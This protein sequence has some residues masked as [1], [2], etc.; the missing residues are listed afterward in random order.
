M[1]GLKNN[2]SWVHVNSVSLNITKDEYIFEVLFRD[3]I[4]LQEGK[5]KESKR[6]A[7]KSR[8]GEVGGVGRGKVY[9]R[10]LKTEQ[11][12]LKQKN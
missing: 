3:A 4:L 11:R 6:G 1:Y 8:G 9:Q 10:K 5:V 7:R 12:L 2:T